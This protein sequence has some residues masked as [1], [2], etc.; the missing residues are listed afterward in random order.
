MD[1]FNVATD[2]LQKAQAA[3]DSDPANQAFLTTYDAVQANYQIKGNNA[4]TADAT[5][6]AAEMNYSQKATALEQ[7]KALLYAV[8]QGYDEAYSI[9][10]S[11][12]VLAMNAR[13]NLAD[14]QISYE[15]WK[16]SNARE[17][18][19]DNEGNEDDPTSDGKLTDVEYE[20]ANAEWIGEI[21]I[22]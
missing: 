18:K 8:Q 15:A 5:F 4:K 17:V 14:T 10:K 20:A 11:A 12:E 1:E 3:V 13:K 16:T 19:D 22:I 9:A 2:N 6:K 21:V 7:A